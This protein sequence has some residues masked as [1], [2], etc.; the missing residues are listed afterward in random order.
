MHTKYEPYE[1]IFQKRT[2]SS[3]RFEPRQQN[4]ASLSKILYLHCFSRLSYEMSTRWR[5]TR[6]GCSVLWAFRKSST[7]KSRIFIVFSFHDHTT[8]A[9]PCPWNVL[10]LSLMSFI[11]K[12]KQ[13]NFQ[14]KYIYIYILHIYFRFILICIFVCIFVEHLPKRLSII[15]HRTSCRFALID[16]TMNSHLQFDMWKT[17]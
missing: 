9:K 10:I 16:M 6:E 4:V 17:K 1:Y 13:R 3:W 12:I 8:Y 11:K 14:K 2:D 15:V 5:K 7:Y